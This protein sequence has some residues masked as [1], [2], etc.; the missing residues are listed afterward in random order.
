MSLLLIVGL[1]LVVLF[2]LLV[3]FGTEFGNRFGTLY[4]RKLDQATAAKERQAANGQESFGCIG[5]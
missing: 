3:V 4:Q 2:F 1:F 5:S